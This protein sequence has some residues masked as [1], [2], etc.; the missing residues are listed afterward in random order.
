MSYKLEARVKP[1]FSVKIIPEVPSKN[2]I[3]FLVIARSNFK[4]RVTAKNVEI[5][6]S[7]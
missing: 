5:F 2:I 6:Y 7:D 4:E 3:K 1:L